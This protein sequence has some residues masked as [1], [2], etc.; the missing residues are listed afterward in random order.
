MAPIPHLVLV[1]NVPGPASVRVG[2]HA[3]KEHLRGSIQHGPCSTALPEIL[4]ASIK[5]ATLDVSSF[6]I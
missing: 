6:V 5:P 4:N 2:R 3:L 1:N